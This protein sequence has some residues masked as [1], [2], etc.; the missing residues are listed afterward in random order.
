[1]LAHSSLVLSM[2]DIQLITVSVS[3]DVLLVNV[4]L[5]VIWGEVVRREGNSKFKGFS[6]AES[7]HDRSCASYF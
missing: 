5:R 7:Y 1:M 4:Q 3:H 6:S 2:C